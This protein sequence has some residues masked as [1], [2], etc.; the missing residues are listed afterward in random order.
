MKKWMGETPTACQ[1]CRA[2]I[3]GKFVDGATAMGPWAF[4]CAACHKDYG[5]GLGTGRGQLYV[6]KGKDFVK[7]EG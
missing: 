3:K 2:P 5:C 1:I 7:K 6:L 4:M